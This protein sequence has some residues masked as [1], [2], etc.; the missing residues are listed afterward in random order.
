MIT[1]VKYK[2]DAV[3]IHTET[4]HGKE[5]AESVW[6]C[7]EKPHPDF[8][9]AFSGLEKVVREILDI[10]ALVWNGRIKVDSVSFSDS[11]TTGVRGSVITGH[12]ELDTA[13]SPFNFNTP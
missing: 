3:E 6:K 9:L 13:N 8:A 11:E 5:S 2:N 7:T 10:G 12:V 4:L 1:K